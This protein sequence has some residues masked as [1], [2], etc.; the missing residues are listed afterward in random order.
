MQTDAKQKRM[1]QII[2]ARQKHS[3]SLLPLKGSSYSR[4]L[5]LSTGNR[6]NAAAKNALLPKQEGIC[7]CKNLRTTNAFTEKD[8]SNEPTFRMN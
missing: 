7:M 6:K 3:Y 1:L 8:G 5:S 2:S 4:T